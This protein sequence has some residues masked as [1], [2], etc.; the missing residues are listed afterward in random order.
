AA[1]TRGDE[2]RIGQGLY[3]PSS[4]QD[5]SAT[6]AVVDLAVRGGYAGLGAPNPDA[7]DFDLYR[8][9]LSGDL[10]GDDGPPGSFENYNDNARHLM[11]ITDT[12]GSTII[13]GLMFTASGV[14]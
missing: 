11:T 1:A 7:R 5:V 6:F 8:T 9:I 14:D 3:K 10:L 4:G 13:E 12:D 2:L